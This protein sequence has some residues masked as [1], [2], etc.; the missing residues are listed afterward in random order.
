VELKLKPAVKAL[1]LN[2]LR[3]GEF[4]QCRGKLSDGTGYCCLGVLSELASREGVC[5]KEVSEE[6]FMVRN[7]SHAVPMTETTVRYDGDINY[8]PYEVTR[9]AFEDA[10]EYLMPIE[11]YI[12]ENPSVLASNGDMATKTTLSQ[13]NDQGFT[14]EQIADII[15]EQM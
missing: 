7:G 15:E 5:E 6:T 4:E 1:W 3:S 9:W 12:K 13:L 2:G 8:L 10:D 14:F 11:H